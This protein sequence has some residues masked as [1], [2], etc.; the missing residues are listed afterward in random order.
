MSIQITAMSDLGDAL[1][2][3]GCETNVMLV[4]MFRWDKIPLTWELVIET[5]ALLP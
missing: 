5:D 1:T 2:T 3:Q 4:N